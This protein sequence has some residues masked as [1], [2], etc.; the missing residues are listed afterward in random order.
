MVGQKYS[1]GAFRKFVL[2]QPRNITNICY[3]LSYGSVLGAVFASMFPVRHQ[4]FLEDLILIIDHQDNI[5][6]LVI[7]GV[8]NSED[9]FASKL[10]V[11]FP[12]IVFVVNPSLYSFLAQ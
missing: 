2:L 11:K 3:L 8:L 6:R 1:I 5:E 9:Y 10:H 12:R 4:C 7:D